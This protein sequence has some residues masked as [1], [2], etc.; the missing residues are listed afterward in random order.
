MKNK[1]P[2]I[3]GIN[4]PHDEL[5]QAQRPALSGQSRWGSTSISP[6]TIIKKPH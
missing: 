4:L 2:Q 1:Y 3:F 5:F 6:R